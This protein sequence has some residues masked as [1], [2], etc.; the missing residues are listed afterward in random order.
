MTVHV[1]SSI[2]TDIEARMRTTSDLKQPYYKYTDPHVH[3]YLNYCHQ[4]FT[5]LLYT[6]KISNYLRMYEFMYKNIALYKILNGNFL[7]T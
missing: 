6:D 4:I 5:S 2:L 7:Q 1:S 3:V